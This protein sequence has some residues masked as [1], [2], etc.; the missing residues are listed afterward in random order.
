[1]ELRMDIDLEKSP[2]NKADSP[3]FPAIHE[4]ATYGTM[5]TKNYIRDQIK[6]SRYAALVEQGQ[7][8]DYFRRIIEEI[9]ARN[10]T[11]LLTIGHEYALALGPLDRMLDRKIS[12]YYSFEQMP[13][14]CEIQA[15]RLMLSPAAEKLRLEPLGTGREPEDSSVRRLYFF[16]LGARTDP[17][18]I[19][20]IEESGL[21]RMFLFIWNEGLRRY[22]NARYH[23]LKG[24]PPRELEV[25]KV[26]EE[27]PLPVILDEDGLI[28]RYTETTAVELEE[29]KD[30]RDQLAQESSHKSEA[31]IKIGAVY[32]AF[33]KE[34]INYRDLKKAMLEAGMEV[35]AAAIEQ[36]GLSSLRDYIRKHGVTGAR[37]VALR[38]DFVCPAV[39]ESE[40][41]QARHAIATSFYSQAAKSRKGRFFLR[42]EV[43]CN[44]QSMVSSG[45]SWKLPGGYVMSMV[46]TIDGED[47]YLFGKYPSR[48]EENTFNLVT[49]GNFYFHEM[50]IK[51]V[52][53]VVR[54]F[55]D[56]LAGGIRMNNAIRK[57]LIA[58]PIVL[59]LAALVGILY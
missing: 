24:I 47:H 33:D 56:S 32:Q 35:E 31:L 16:I 54:Y 48:D 44:M 10:Y 22:F 7:P 2:E 18:T 15:L 8:K 39:S 17:D 11:G 55:I 28:R 4:L 41:V 14:S 1:M 57:M 30:L 38:Y 59:G 3:G 12:Q 58:L 13:K 50:P 29:A 5:F 36:E 34:G 21:E 25:F 23:A 53:G 43:L 26:I 9:S 42:S 20:L 49:L 51:A 6:T 46:H 37:E 27:L 45:E 52:S 19:A 40:P